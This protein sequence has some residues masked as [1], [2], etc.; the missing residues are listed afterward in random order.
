MEPV[1]KETH[2][3]ISNVFSEKKIESLSTKVDRVVLDPETIE[4][5]KVI[6]IQVQKALGELIE[7]SIKDVVN[8]I[9]QERSQPLV[10]AEL[11]KIQKQ[12][13][14]IVKALQYAT[15]KAKRAKSAGKDISIDDILKYIQTPIVIEKQS[16]ISTRGRKKKVNAPSDTSI[17]VVIDCKPNA[18]LDS[19]IKDLPSN[20]KI[21]SKFERN[22]SNQELN[23][24]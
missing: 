17:D 11:A 18:S 10:E 23:S 9:L 1:I 5:I 14:D 16:P 6:S 21:A 13:F 8:F 2:E 20:K 24:P 7:I 12:K 4:V 3:N 22:S 19:D 15:E